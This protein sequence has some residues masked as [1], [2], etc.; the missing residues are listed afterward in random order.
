[1]KLKF[2]NHK[3]EISIGTQSF[4]FS[5]VYFFTV[6]SEK[7]KNEDSWVA[8]NVTSIYKVISKYLFPIKRNY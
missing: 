7:S 4:S 2:C 3:L 8:K 5:K 1:M 6:Y